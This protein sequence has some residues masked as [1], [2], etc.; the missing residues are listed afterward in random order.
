MDIVYS[1]GYTQA[2][3]GVSGVQIKV[4]HT[5]SI[6]EENLM[7]TYYHRNSCVSMSQ[8]EW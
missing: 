2:Q 4:S 6:V 7:L 8:R 3:R 1:S 5:K